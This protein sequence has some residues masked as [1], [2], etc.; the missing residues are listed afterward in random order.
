MA[1][2]SCFNLETK[3]YQERIDEAI[4]VKFLLDLTLHSLV[5]SGRSKKE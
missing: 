1:Y 4:Q 3:E 2:S 5:G